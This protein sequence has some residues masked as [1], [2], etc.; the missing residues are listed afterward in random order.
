M[1]SKLLLTI[2]DIL[3]ECPKCLKTSLDNGGTIE[4]TPKYVKRV[5]SCGYSVK[6]TIDESMDGDNEEKILKG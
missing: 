6:F 1:D 4:I 5:C 3:T 2:A